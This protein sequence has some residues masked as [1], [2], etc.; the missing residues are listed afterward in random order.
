MVASL[1]SRLA[2]P[3]STRRPDWS[4][5][6]I[7]LK[8][9]SSSCENHSRTT[10]GARCT[11]LPTDGVAWSRNAWARAA[12]A[13][14]SSAGTASMVARHRTASL[15]EE[16]LPETV[17]EE[18]V[19]EEVQL[20]DAADVAPRPAVHRNDRLGADLEV[21]PGPDDARIDRAGGLA[22]EAAVQGRREAELDE[23]N[24]AVEGRRQAHVAHEG[25]QVLQAVL[26][27]E[28]GL[29]RVG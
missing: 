17:R 9:G 5:T 13:A 18:I 24:E 8:A 16:R 6:S 4:T 1:A 3:S 23:R 19:E 25:L 26:D 21:L 15:P 27:G 29:E 20:D 10:A 22:G 28:A 11:V 7:V 2:F 12:G 14:R